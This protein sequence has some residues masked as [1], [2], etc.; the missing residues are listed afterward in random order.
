MSFQNPWIGYIDRTYEQM[1][2][3]ILTKLPVFV[4]ELTDS[5][6][7]NILVRMISIWSGM[8]EM[9]GYYIDNAAR[10]AFLSTSRRYDSAIKI[11]QLFDYRIR[12]VKPASADITFT[13]SA[14]VGSDVSIP[15]GTKLSTVD[16]IDFVTTRPDTILAGETEIIIPAT[17]ETA[18]ASST[19]GTSDG[20][21]NQAFELIAGISDTSIKVTVG[22]IEYTF[23]ESLA[24]SNNSDR[25]FTSSLNDEQKMEIRFGDGLQGIIPPIGQTIEVEYSTSVGS[26]GNLA[27]NTITTLV[28]I[29]TVPDA[30]TLSVTNLNRSS[31]GANIESLT[32]LKKNIP[33]SIR[34]L[35]R[36]VTEQ[37]FIDIAELVPGV[38]KADVRYDCSTSADVFI[39]PTGGGTATEQLLTEVKNAFHDDTRIILVE[40]NP[41]PAGEVLIRLDILLRVI[42]IFDTIATIAKLKDVLSTFVSAENQDI[43]GELNIGD[44]YQQAEDTEG[45]QNTEIT[46]LTLIPVARIYSGVNELDWVVELLP[47]SLAQTTWRIRHRDAT[48][49]ELQQG[50]N[51]LGTYN[52]GQ[53]VVTQAVKFTINNPGYD[54]GDI[55]DFNTY[56][57]NGSINLDEPSI[58]VLRE[59]NINVTLF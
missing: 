39:V 38:A 21:A 27:E 28:D 44:L 9:L 5:T 18:V 14:P 10:E 50:P 7:N 4:P 52:Y 22:G 3:S 47:T 35:D 24:F 41:R 12:G 32:D 16:N 40:V 8:A 30:Q 15:I 1:K 42:P 11:S 23:Q 2:Q 34:T 56:R 17:Q 49:F 25:V 36:A 51:V 33:L 53:E 45:V 55:W 37:D 29:I 57:Y 43:S 6:E 58:P 54:V 46:L 26:N 13:L 19:I 20:T 31:G 59:E 48:S